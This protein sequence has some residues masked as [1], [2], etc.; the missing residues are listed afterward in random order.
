MKIRKVLIGTLSAVMM[1]GAVLTVSASELVVPSPFAKAENM[2]TAVGTDVFVS[3]IEDQ[4]GYFQWADMKNDPARQAD[5]NAIEKAN[6]LKRSEASVKAFQEELKNS[7][8]AGKDAVIAAL[9]GKTWLS[10]FFEVLPTDANN[11]DAPMEV[12]LKVKGIADVSVND[13]SFVHY[14][15]ET[16]WQVLTILKKDGENV[17][18]KFDGFSPAAIAM[19]INKSVV[20][21]TPTPA[22]AA[23]NNASPKTGV[24]TH[25]AAFAV[26]AVLLAVCAAAFSRKKRA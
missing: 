6:E 15:P 3:D 24:A 4:R 7:T 13:L 2:P 5:V 16:G 14:D 10:T 17:T 9:N 19:A 18:V 1:L 25:W 21:V 26:A 22:P 8:A 11:L 12:T 23:N 20:P